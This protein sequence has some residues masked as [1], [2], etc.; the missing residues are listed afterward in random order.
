MPPKAKFSREE[1]ITAAIDLVK[2]EG[3]EK[4]TARSLAQKLG[5]SPRP[6]FTVFKSMDEVFAEVELSAR[7][8]YESYEDE[9]MSGDN[10]FK[11][12]GLGYVRFAA[13]EPKLFQMLFMTEQNN[14]P[15]IN[16]VL[17]QIDGYSEKIL[18]SVEQEYGFVRETAEEIYLH[19][20]IY[21]HGIAVLLATNVCKFT[22]QEISQML[23]EVGSS[24]IKKFKQ[25]GRK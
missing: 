21:T 6:I 10:A 3:A 2:K 9:G 16:N 19:L 13:N 5:S 25:E 14:V 17:G 20:W 7:K 1:I 8:L 23:N 22:E 11:G 4:L 24:I 18:K 12:S 15:N